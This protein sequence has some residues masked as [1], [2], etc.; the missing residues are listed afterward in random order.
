MFLIFTSLISF[1][2]DQYSLSDRV[3]L[4][5]PDMCEFLGL[6]TC[7]WLGLLLMCTNTSSHFIMT[8]ESLGGKRQMEVRF[9]TLLFLALL[10]STWLSVNYWLLGIC[11]FFCFRFFIDSCGWGDRWTTYKGLLLWYCFTTRPEEVVFLFLI[12]ILISLCNANGLWFDDV[13]CS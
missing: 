6:F 10:W 1:C 13:V 11:L 4:W 8:I 12:L 3:W 2:V 9:Y 5:I 7:D